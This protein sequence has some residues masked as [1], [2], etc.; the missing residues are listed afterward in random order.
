MSWILIDDA[1]PEVNQEVYYYFDVVGVWKGT[2]EGIDDTC[3]LPAFSSKGGFLV[4]DV[5]HWQ[6]A[7]INGILV[8]KPKE[9]SKIEKN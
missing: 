8:D 1:L 2:Y 5:T 9:P 3:G 4:G 7:K 6:P